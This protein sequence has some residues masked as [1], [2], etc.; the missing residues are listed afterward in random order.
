VQTKIYRLRLIQSN[1]LEV[2]RLMWSWP[3]KIVLLI[4]F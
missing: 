3:L 2:R 1:L 4:T